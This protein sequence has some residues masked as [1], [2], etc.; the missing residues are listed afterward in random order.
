MLASGVNIWNLPGIC[1]LSKVPDSGVVAQ[2]VGGPLLCA[3]WFLGTLMGEQLL[4]M[5]CLM[6]CSAQTMLA[7]VQST[8]VPGST[9]SALGQAHAGHW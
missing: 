5:H 6:S 2:S 3:G 4:L 8:I 1:R 7:A 9:G